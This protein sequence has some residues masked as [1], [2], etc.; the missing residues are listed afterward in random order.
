MSRGIHRRRSIPHR[1][2]R[3]AI[4]G[5]VRCVELLESRQLLS[6]VTTFPVPGSGN[7]SFS[8]EGSSAHIVTGP[9][10][11]LW[12]TDT[13]NNQID[14]VTLAGQVTQFMLPVHNVI[15]TSG[16]G[17]S[18]N[19][20]GSG[21]GGSPITPL[22]IIDPILSPDD[23]APADIVVG[24]DGNLWFTESGVDR[25]G[26]ITPS[27][28][29]TEFTTPTADSNP[30]GLIA[31]ADGNLWF[32]E[33]GG[34]AIGRITPA[35]A[36]TEFSV[37]SLDVSYSGGITQGP[38]GNV[39][40]LAADSDGNGEIAKISPAGHVANFPL[41]SDPVDLTTGPDG[42]LWV[43]T[44]DGEID[45]V[46]TAGAVTR[47]TIP[48]GDSASSIT[49]GPDG[50][51]WFAL[52]G[53]N[54]LGRI[55]T[56]GAV[57]EF[58][59]PDPNATD[60]STISPG[61]LTTGPDNNLWFVDSY[62]PQVGFLNVRNALL[63]S[64]T[65]ATATAGTTSS[66]QLATFTDFSGPS[67]SDNYSATITWSDGTTSAGSI[68][69]DPNG[70]FDVSGS[71]D[72]SLEDNS[73]TVTITDTR[74]AGRTTSAVSYVSVTAPQPVGT[75][76]TVS[77]TTAQLFSGTVA[78]FT[79]VALNSLS[80][81]SASIDW[82]DGQTSQGTIT[83]NASGG[84]DVAG[85][86]R[87]PAS[88]TYTVTV[89]LSP[90][91]GGFLYP[92]GGGGGIDPIALGA[93]VNTVPGAKPLSGA[94]RPVALPKAV[95]GAVS[96]ARGG[97]ATGISKGGTGAI[98]IFPIPIDPLPPIRFP[99]IA[100]ATSTMSVAPGAM[101][102][103]GYS[104]Q[105]TTAATFSGTVAS[106]TLTDPNEDLSHL[107][108]TVVWSDPY[109]R[110]WFTVSNPPTTGTIASDGQ[111]GFTVSV[112]TNFTDFGWSHFTVN[113]TDD[114]LGTADTA[115]VGVA[116]G[117]LIVD[118][119]V[120]WIPILEAQ[121]ASAGSANT[122]AAKATSTAASTAASGVNPVF[123]EQVAATAMPFHT[124][125]AGLASG[126][127]GELTGVV[128]NARKLADLHGTINWG[129]G[130]SS[131][132]TFVAGAKGKVFVRG[133]HKYA[134]PGAFS[135][136]TNLQQT[137]YSNGKASSLYPLALPTI[138]TSTVVP[139][140]HAITTGGVAIT[141]TAGQAFSGTL[142][143]F[144]A[145]DPGVS[146][147]RVATIFWGDGTHSTGDIATDGNDLAVTGTHIY[148]RPG[149]RRVVV[150][151]TQSPAQRPVPAGTV[152][153]AILA[154]ILTTATVIT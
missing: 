132:A 10:G 43:A 63:A 141:A 150:V 8:W 11:N 50:A 15:D 64:G 22:P 148:A 90:W 36:I 137:L 104:V 140:R 53:T 124:G 54:E 32:T 119:P 109:V 143:Q 126:N 2:G 95:S 147:N 66:V 7:D 153:P 142:A 56:A 122:P 152:V 151:V 67:T 18:G 72:W 45:K 31:G 29:I 110:D 24:P 61:A 86:T 34:N 27:G 44:Y 146:V 5:A 111:G 82:G 41:G 25:I 115:I 4:I 48:T 51:L 70:G 114:R 135:V 17:L 35:G 39:W 127:V 21:I 14:R 19:G 103:T 65:D 12:F 138:Q 123:S 92:L 85:S 69:A 13:G 112:S 106:F 84:I 102:G 20:S 76:V 40:F 23:P 99:G 73:V 129:D 79:G 42:N 149:K 93:P 91:P 74:T 134:Q 77:T 33:S 121:G 107:H 37:G 3:T 154:R 78:S 118:S 55:T 144:T 139:L 9:D 97:V 145:P 71:R 59:L 128:S 28:T 46:T 116:Y 38:D 83:A 100:S 49:N 105:A 131:P 26:R 57:S 130:T 113:I 58:S 30:L 133:N 101:D 125:A 117:Q 1:G 62:T 108:A 60:G 68:A 80:S 87:Y 98:S 6:A 81:Y 88:G 94:A 120:K 47:F 52:D 89:S 16:G 136:T 96:S 75:G